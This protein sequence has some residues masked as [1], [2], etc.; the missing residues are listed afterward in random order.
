MG[1]TKRQFV[2][3]AFSKIGLGYAYNLTPEE[4]TD[5]L[6]TLD[7]MMANW[8]GRGL[9][10]SYP[11]PSSPEFSD[12]DSETNVPDYANE[13]IILNL[14]VRIGQTLGRESQ[15][16]RIDA[17]TAYRDVFSRSAVIPQMQYPETMPRGAGNR[18]PHYSRFYNPQDRLTVGKD[19]FLNLKE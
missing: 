15:S 1:Y 12:F 14:A 2:R 5:A 10:L 11:L 19:A 4:E 6:E 13:A 7:A 17:N 18:I 9:R 16:L 3:K 8:N